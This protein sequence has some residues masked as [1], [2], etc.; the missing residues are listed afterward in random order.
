VGA[1]GLL[2]L[3]ASLMAAGSRRVL[4]SLWPVDDEATSALMQAFFRIWRGAGDAAR[5]DAA[6]A[7]RL[8]MEEVAGVEKWKAPR[9]WAA[10]VLWGG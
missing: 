9:Y 5:P 3:P 4:A 8:A 7:L 2:G 10:W 1:E 6:R